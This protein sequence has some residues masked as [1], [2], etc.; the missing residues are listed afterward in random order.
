MTCRQC[1]TE[2]ADKALICYR[3]GTA[4]TE[5][6]HQAYARPTRRSGTTMAMAVGVLAALVLVAWFLLHSQWP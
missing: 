6:T 5:P 2:I 3:C 1:G 4:T